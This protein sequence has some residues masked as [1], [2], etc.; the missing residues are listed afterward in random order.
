M[1]DMMPNSMAEG[2]S[3]N[4]DYRIWAAW[5]ACYLLSFLPLIYG[6]VTVCSAYH[7]STDKRLAGLIVVLFSYVVAVM[8]ISPRIMKLCDGKG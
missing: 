6:C 4:F 3:P 7:L 1:M 5:K 8:F 2:R